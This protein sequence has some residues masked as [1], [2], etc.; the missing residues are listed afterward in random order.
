MRTDD[1]L[2]SGQ[3]FTTFLSSNVGRVVVD[4]LLFRFSISPPPLPEIFAIKIWSCP[5]SCQI[6]DVFCPAK[7]QG[8]GPPTL[9][10]RL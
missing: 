5:K 10:P 8:G 4:H 2:L 7:F 9:G 1:F 6:L 3:K